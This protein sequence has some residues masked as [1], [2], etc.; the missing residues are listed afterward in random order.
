MTLEISS[1]WILAQI[2]SDASQPHME[3]LI[4]L[5]L[6]E[7]PFVISSHKKYEDLDPELLFS[8]QIL[9]FDFLAPIAHLTAMTAVALY[10]NSRTQSYTAIYTINPNLN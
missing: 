2:Q 9:W 3:T 7:Q 1:F 10:V 5:K 6:L 4:P 8:Y